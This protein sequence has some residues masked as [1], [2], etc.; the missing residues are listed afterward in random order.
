MELMEV[1]R[2]SD[3]LKENS[4]VYQPQGEI[5]SLFVIPVF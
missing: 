1:P 3:D 2:R 4:I 5:G